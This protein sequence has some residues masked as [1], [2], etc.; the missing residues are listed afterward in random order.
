[1][2]VIG[3]ALR[4][5]TNQDSYIAYEG[6]MDEALVLACFDG[7]G[8][9]GH[10]VAEAAANLLPN[11][12]IKQ[13]LTHGCLDAEPLRNAFIDIDRMIVNNREGYDAF[14]SGA[15]A[16]VLVKWGDRLVC[17][18]AGDSRCLIGGVSPE[19]KVLC[20]PL[21]KEHGPD[22]PEEKMRVLAAGA[23]LDRLRSHAGIDEGPLRVY[24]WEADSP[25]IT[26]TRSIGDKRYRNVGL[27]PEPEVLEDHVR[28]E[29][30]YIVLCSDG[31]TEFMTD[32]Q[33]MQMVHSGARHHL[34][35]VLLAQQI[36]EEARR[37]WQVRWLIFYSRR[38]SDLIRM[39]ALIN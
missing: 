10:K 14:G 38:E 28:P 32:L 5:K 12:L 15:T 31:I 35:P 13:C 6:L 37:L 30:R 21:S 33:I 20:R 16:T 18:N 25:G 19:G 3:S 17:A 27:T 9:D 8:A 29:D 23:R 24:L 22:L 34:H 36:V 2:S 1:M 4:S 26:V 11:A 7:H 39:P